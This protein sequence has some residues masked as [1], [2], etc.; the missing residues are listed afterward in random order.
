MRNDVHLFIFVLAM[1]VFGSG[2][3]FSDV[4]AEVNQSVESFQEHVVGF[5]FFPVLGCVCVQL[6]KNSM[7]G[8]IWG[9]IRYIC[10]RMFILSSEGWGIE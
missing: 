7:G 1:Y 10:I 2:E 6:K 3:C 8:G 5:R 4:V 9:N